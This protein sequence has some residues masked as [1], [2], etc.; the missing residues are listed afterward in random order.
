MMQFSGAQYLKM[1]VA[2]KFGLD[3][4]NWDV[5]LAWF[6]ENEHRLEE[7]VSQ[8]DEQAGFL[9]GV[10]AY[11]KAKSGKA[12]GYTISLDATS[13]GVQILAALAGCEKSARTCNL[14][15]TGNREDA[16]TIVY[17]SMNRELGANGYAMR[18][19]VK[20]A[21]MTSL[22]GSK[23]EPR[24]V[25]GEKS[26]EL[27]QFY[28]TMPV[29]L[30][31]AW[32]LN[33]EL[34][35][36][37]NPN[38]YK[39]SFTLAD[40]FDVVLKVMDA[41][42]TTVHFNGAP[43][44]IIQHVNQPKEGEVSLAANIVHSIDGMIVR[45]MQRRCQ[46]DRAQIES[47]LAITTYG[48]RT[49]RKKDQELLRL[50]RLYRESQFMSARIFQY[51]DGDNSGHFSHAERLEIKYLAEGMLVHRP[52]EIL[53]IHDCFR[54]LPNYGNHLRYHYIEIMAQIARSE[55]LSHIA[56]QLTGRK[57]IA[58][59]KADIS[60]LILEAEYPIC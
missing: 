26:K 18:D 58:K 9:A 46:Y 42:E 35:S 11:R 28:K 2:S 4:E 25:F 56:S 13:S 33:E 12:T 38:A 15:N 17:D 22:Y 57:V 52:F 55:L 16:Y 43:Y 54:C 8:A 27:A 47:V 31:G 20:I 3:K 34:I 21:V 1:D 49:D 60:S 50:L 10:M 29:E 51:I 48:T 40:G 45:E 59:K 23:A 30:P 36:L 24:K 19:K 14:I 5:R 37:W 6:H 41:V 7:L 44:D 32:E 39:H 53:T